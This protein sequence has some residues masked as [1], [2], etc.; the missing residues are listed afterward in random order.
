MRRSL[1]EAPNRKNEAA[2]RCPGTLEFRNH[3]FASLRLA[4]G[5]PV[6]YVSAQLEHANPSTTLR[7]S[8]RW[9]PTMGERWVDVL[10]RS[11]AAVSRAAAAVGA[12]FDARV[13]PKN[14]N[15]AS[16]PPAGVSEMV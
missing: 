5:A 4:A 1:S 13:E 8:A 6:T 12:R 16:Y 15:Q 9:I 2:P 14:G 10:D 7:F 3:T 11:D